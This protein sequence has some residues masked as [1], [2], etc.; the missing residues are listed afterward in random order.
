MIV[1]DARIVHEQGDPPLS[2]HVAP[3]SQRIA[4]EAGGRVAHLGRIARITAMP[5]AVDLDVVRLD[6]VDH[7]FDHLRR[8]PR[9]HAVAI[10]ARVEVEMD[11]EKGIGPLH[12]RRIGSFHAT[13]PTRQQTIAPMTNRIGRC[14]Q[15]ADCL[16]V[17]FIWSSPDLLP[18]VTQGNRPPTPARGIRKRRDSQAG[19]SS[20]F[21]LAARIPTEGLL[22][23][24]GLGADFRSSRKCASSIRDS[25]VER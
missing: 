19:T 8:C 18:P 1:P 2:C 5:F 7:Q 23:V 9:P 25:G 12:P 13:L 22:D 6:L 20:S 24:I 10:V 11:A 3:D 16:H 21:R 4:D 17:L 15:P 14:R